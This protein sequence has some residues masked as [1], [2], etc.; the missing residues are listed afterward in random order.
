MSG[1][2]YF[3][4]SVSNG[5]VIL[6][7]GIKKCK[8]TFSFSGEFGEGSDAFREI[9]DGTLTEVNRAEKP[10]KLPKVARLL[11]IPNRSELNPQQT[12]S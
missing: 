8:L 1:K 12:W 6:P 7:H 2:G 10:S 9:R 3:N 5:S 11:A 4:D